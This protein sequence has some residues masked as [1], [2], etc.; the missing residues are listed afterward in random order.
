ITI[1]EAVVWTVLTYFVIGYDLEVGRLFR[2]FLLLI[3]INQMG[4][5]LFRFLGA[6]GREMTVALTLASFIFCF[7]VAM[8]GLALSRGTSTTVH[9]LK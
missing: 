5:G 9:R 2:Q 6:V 3:L 4:T 1:V 7:L 8:G